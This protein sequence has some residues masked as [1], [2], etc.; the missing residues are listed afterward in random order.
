MLKI[1]LTRT[2]KRGQPHYRIIVCEARSKRDGKVMDNLGYY[3]P[4]TNPSE[5][6]ID[7]E[8]YSHWIQKG[9]QPTLTVK[10][11]AKRIS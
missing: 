4:L 8:K 9:A 11:L 6:K 3:N 1:R 7:K 10:N 2:G 5:V